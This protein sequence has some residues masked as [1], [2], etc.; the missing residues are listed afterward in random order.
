[1]PAFVPC[2]E[3]YM[4]IA[5]AL[6]T[7]L[8]LAAFPLEAAE[9][10]YD[11]ASDKDSFSGTDGWVSHYCADPWTTKGTSG[12]F[13]RT[14]DGCN[15][16]GGAS[17]C[18]FGFD[19]SGKS[20]YFSDAA[21]NHLTFGPGTWKNFIYE[22][23]LLF[24][25][26]DSVGFVFRYR[27]SREFY[28][29]VLSKDDAVQPA[30]VCNE[31]LAGARLMR[32]KAGQ[33]STLAEKAGVGWEAG[34][35]HAVRITAVDASLKFE[36]DQN[37]DG[38]FSPTELVFDLTDPDPLTAGQ[39]GFYAYNAGLADECQGKD[40]RFGPVKVQVLTTVADPCGGIGAQGKCVGAT[41][42]Y[43]YEGQL[44]ESWCN[45]CCLWSADNQAHA[46]A[47]DASQCNTCADECVQ[48]SRGCN[49]ELKSAW[50]CGQGDADTCLERLYEP[51]TGL[52]VCDPLQGRCLG[53]C[54][55]DC[56]SKLC[57]DD[58][59][60]G[61]C[62]TCPENFVCTVGQC[63]QNCT[64]DCQGKDCGSNG[65][66]GNC[67]TCTAPGFCS[68][69]GLCSNKGSCQGVCDHSFPDWGCFCDEQC[70]GYN[71][72][73]EDICQACPQLSH[74]DPCEADCTN[75]DCGSDGCGGSCGA[76][77]QGETCGAQGL[78]QGPPPLTTCNG[79]LTCK[80]DCPIGNNPCL[81]AC[82]ERAT[83]AA[84]AAY[85]AF[86]SCTDAAC[87]ACGYA[88]SCLDTC[89]SAAC[90]DFIAPCFPKPTMNC[91]Q[92]WLCAQDCMM[93]QDC[94]DVCVLKG[95]PDA[96]T[97]FSKLRQCLETQCLDWTLECLTIAA[98]DACHDQLTACTGQC[99][100]SC[101]NKECGDDL[102]DGSCGTCFDSQFCVNGKCQS[103]PT[104]TPKDHQ[105]C[106]GNSLFWFDSCGE[107][108]ALVKVCLH[109]CQGGLC[110]EPDVS[111]D[112]DTLED[113]SPGLD[114]TPGPDDLTGDIS[115]TAGKGGSG[116]CST[117]TPTTTP[118][119]LLLALLLA[120][121]LSRQRRA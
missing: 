84:G 30:G 111:L 63:L 32:V 82:E 117:G 100:P 105:S 7:L 62:G 41:L 25:G 46:C 87:P 26:G 71:D 48:G 22:S 33:G 119:L 61:S 121:L 43:C 34:K 27:H 21:D 12:V 79:V 45:T 16:C 15:A 76:C 103:Q 57:G 115:F 31:K 89:G 17:N 56:A 113:S 68:G 106:E 98:G 24:H 85:D 5:L 110:L 49:A 104:C 40:C 44:K 86:T 99:L 74:C 114:T 65:C 13:P 18:T 60:G 50:A 8:L 95:L 102:C 35:T 38:A 94:L 53:S 29:V 90:S 28:A 58:G 42:R 19:K 54:V 2:P 75:R 10:T 4:K 91:L 66:G 51:C 77:P 55:P 92:L 81:A 80:A 20:C 11:F 116:G 78:C 6:A 97:K 107:K 83:Q 23:D 108:G 120:G 52:G 3:T 69:A 96:N 59:C 36:F 37:A 67:G 39:V 101:Y 88:L 109:G 93:D 9:F 112:K 1:M 64:P 14:D 70:V 72:C 118:P 73:C 47:A